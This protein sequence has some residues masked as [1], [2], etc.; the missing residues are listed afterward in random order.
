MAPMRTAGS[1][2]MLIQMESQAQMYKKNQQVSFFR[3][4]MRNVSSTAL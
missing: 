3:L 1:E 4:F 2:A